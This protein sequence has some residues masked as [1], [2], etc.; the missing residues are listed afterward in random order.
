MS[1]ALPF[2]TA[3][4]GLCIAVRVSP[5]SAA[6]RIEGIERDAAGHP[7]FKVKVTAVPEGGKANAAVVALLARAWRVPK[8]RM[9]IAAGAA[10]RRKT[11]LIEGGDAALLADLTEW[12]KA[13]YDGTP[14]D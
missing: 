5:R 7:Y 4:D 9:R 8:R 10:S 3:R 1:R 14:S 6:S 2:R 13:R 11:I 12:T